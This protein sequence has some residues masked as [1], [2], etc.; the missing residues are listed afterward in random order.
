MK[1]DNTHSRLFFQFLN[2]LEDN[3]VR[4]V[5]IRG[6]GEFPRSGDTDVDLVYH[7]DDHDEYVKL[8]KEHLIPYNSGRG[9]EWASMG[10]GEWCEMLYLPCK[11]PGEP[12]PDIHNG[13]FRV[14]AY[15]SLHF[16][17][18]YNNFTTFWTVDKEYNDQVIDS[19]YKVKESY[20][21]YYLPKKE[22]EIALLVARNVL[23]NKK[24]PKWNTKHKSRIENIIE[25]V[26]R[27][28][29][30]NRVSRLFPNSKKIVELIYN[31]KYES[32]MDYALGR[33]K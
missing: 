4:Y 28:V 13:C 15:N 10:S 3:K 17:T 8:A 11:T 23:D 27:E 19:R 29:L 20:G 1:K 18:P 5:I 16:K 12:D 24:R 2:A 9:S 33:K 7:I 14:D 32:T 21:S 30:E 31:K 6:F 25:S 22:D 26:D